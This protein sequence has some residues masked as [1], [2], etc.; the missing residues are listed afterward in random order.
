MGVYSRIYGKLKNK[1][2]PSVTHKEV[3][4]WYR[5]GGDTRLRFN[6]E[7][8][9]D[10]VV[11]DLGG[12]EGGFASDLYSRMPCK[13]Y[14]FEPVKSFYDDMVDRFRLNPDISVFNYGLSSSDQAVDISINGPGSSVHRKS[15][16]STERIALRDITDV[17]SE[18]NVDRI[19]L[20]KINIEGGE[21]DVLPKI[22]DANLLPYIANLQIQFH[23]IDADSLVKKNS[24]RKSLELTHDCIYCY[25]FVWEDWRIKNS[26]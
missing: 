6:Y 3:N 26:V 8:K 16:E 9:P 13:I 25:E 1:F 4:R 10:S 17:I 5:D 20:L 14:S 21:Y 24:I 22:I 23:K 7:L 18:L 19:D 11:F 15:H 12:F 2:F